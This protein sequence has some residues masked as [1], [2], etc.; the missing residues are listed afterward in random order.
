MGF[1]DNQ[2]LFE[3]AFLPTLRTILNAP[4]TSPLSSVNASNVADFLVELTHAQRLVT[5]QGSNAAV[6][7]SVMTITL[8]AR[9]VS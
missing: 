8:P 2:Q 3:E 9:S 4:T 1:S 7:V 5:S 6:R